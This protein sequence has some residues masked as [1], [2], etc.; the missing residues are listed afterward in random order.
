MGMH[1]KVVGLK[2]FGLRHVQR[3]CREFDAVY[4]V[5]S[6]IGRKNAEKLENLV[7]LDHHDEYSQKR[8]STEQCLDF[9]K[10][11]GVKTVLEGDNVVCTDNFDADALLSVFAFANPRAALKQERLLRET[12]VFGD[13]TAFSGDYRIRGRRERKLFY[14][15]L[16]WLNKALELKKLSSLKR[17]TI[18]LRSSVEKL[19]R[20]IRNIEAF[21]KDYKAGLQAIEKAITVARRRLRKENNFLSV[22]DSRKLLHENFIVSGIAVYAAAETPVVL[23]RES[24]NEMVIGVRTGKE[25]KNI[26]LTLLLKRLQRIEDNKRAKWYGRRDVVV[27]SGKSSL[28]LYKIKSLINELT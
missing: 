17:K 4:L 26:D 27:C 25:S 24:K 8:V 12:A 20:A 2:V 5:D 15:M 3:L 22:L 28:S 10:K 14:A 1:I 21:S 11:K 16:G 19:G 18:F 7:V 9:I 6:N 23:R 13:F